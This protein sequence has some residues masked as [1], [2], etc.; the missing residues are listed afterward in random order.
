MLNP[1]F[2]RKLQVFGSSQE[3]AVSQLRQAVTPSA[4][5]QPEAILKP[6]TTLSTCSFSPQHLVAL[7]RLAFVEPLPN[8]VLAEPGVKADTIQAIR[9]IPGRHWIGR[10][11]GNGQREV[12]ILV[13]QDTDLN[14]PVELVYYFHGHN[15]TLAKSLQDP[16]KGLAN[17]LQA[18]QNRV[19]VLPQGPPKAQDYTWM[20]PRH[21]ESMA[22]FQAASEQ[23]LRDLLHPGLQ[24][25]QVTL[26][27][28]SAGGLA[29]MNGARNGMQAHRLDFLDASYGSWASATYQAQIKANPQLD[30]HVVYIPGTQT[31]AD[32]LK[33][34]NKPGITLHTSP[35]NHGLVP[36]HF[37]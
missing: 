2:A 11:P 13:P 3:H 35:V 12:A 1:D 4:S 32:A 24:I 34:K 23:Q 10:L 28:H 19:F 7:S 16:S 18:K 20:N 5:E 30:M 6:L 29:L 31:Q 17:A 33:L 21:K 25:G 26:K 9:E 8:E 22:D 14:Q 15:G 36:R 27:A 37:F